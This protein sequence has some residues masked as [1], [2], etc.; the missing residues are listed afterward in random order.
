ML[1]PHDTRIALDTV[2]E[3]VNTAPES[4]P[5]QGGQPESGRSDG[6]ADIEALYDFARRHRISGVDELHDKDLRAV[7]DVRT[8]FAE[9][10]ATDDARTAASLVNALVAA[11][12][13][14]PQL[15]NH[16]GYDWHVHYFAPD[17]SIADHLAA[18][19]GMA[20]AFIVVAGEQERL[21]RCEAPDCRHAFV[22]LS[23]NRSR[24]YCSSRT[25]GNRL[26][27]AA[28]RA[29]RKEAAG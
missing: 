3:L 11:A 14:T 10:F 15:S 24:R 21:R 6:L 1:I 27:V 5:P 22:D 16:D 12:G 7:R 20:L 25:C 13:T 26:H 28:Y 19:C 4:E 2:V 18:D 17:A 9:I 23:R 8:R 29:R